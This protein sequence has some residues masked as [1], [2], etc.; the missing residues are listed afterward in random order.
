MMDVYKRTVEQ[1]NFGIYFM[2]NF[3]KDLRKSSSIKIKKPSCVKDYEVVGKIIQIKGYKNGR[4]EIKRSGSSSKG[5]LFIN[6]YEINGDSFFE[7]MNE[8]MKLSKEKNTKTLIG[9][10]FVLMLKG[11]PNYAMKLFEKAN[12]LSKDKKEKNTI[13]EF[14]AYAIYDE[15]NRLNSQGKGVKARVLLEKFKKEYKDT[16]AYRDIFDPPVIVPKS[17]VKDDKPG[18]EF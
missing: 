13:R 14:L 9:A 6:L 16:K 17:T 3:E 18:K 1:F 12:G 8:A 10:G 5:N 11:L 2:K 15:V 7:L 4:V